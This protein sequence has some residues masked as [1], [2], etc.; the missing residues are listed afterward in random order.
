MDQAAAA[1]AAPRRDLVG[2][3][4]GQDACTGPPA[5]P[6]PAGRR[7]RAQVLEP[8]APQAEPPDIRLQ[9]E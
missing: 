4:S 1:P 9:T 6:G 5:T 3:S 8:G 7:R 2:R